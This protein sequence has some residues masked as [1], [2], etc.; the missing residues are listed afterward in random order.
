MYQTQRKEIIPDVPEFE[1][2]QHTNLLVDLN[3]VVFSTR[4]AKV[5]NPARGIKEPLVAQFIMKEVIQ[6]IVFH[7]NLFKVDAIAITCDSPNVWRRDIFPTY[8]GNRDKDDIYH[9]ECIEAAMLTKEF[10]T[11]VTNSSVFENPRS[12]ADDCIAVFCQESTGVNNI[13]MS[14]DKDFIQLTN[15]RT[16]LYSPT[17]KTWRTSEDTEF[18]LFL[19]CIRGDTNDNIRSA[20]PRVRETRL[21]NAWDDPVEMMNL[22]ETV[23]KDGVKVLD[24]FEMNLALIGLSEQPQNI[25]DEIIEMIKEETSRRKCYGELKIMKFFH[26]NELSEHKEMLVYKERPLR[27]SV[28]FQA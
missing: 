1:V 14:A 11:T 3:N 5:K 20:F 22:M 8:K 10:F 7:A 17:Q 28:V 21:R 9:D 19:K 4:F 15:G 6:S 24:A 2:D 16:K 25:R 12:E 13:I 27:G 23:R 18:D 26:E